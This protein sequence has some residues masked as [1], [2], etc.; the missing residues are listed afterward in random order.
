[1]TPGVKLRSSRDVILQL[2][3][4]SLLQ[5]IWF[6]W[7]GSH[8]G[9]FRACWWVDLLNQVGCSRERWKTPVINAVYNRDGLLLTLTWTMFVDGEKTTSIPPTCLL[10]RKQSLGSLRWALLSPSVVDG[11]RPGFRKALDVVWLARLACLFNIVWTSGTVPLNWQAGVRICFTKTETVKIC[12][13]V[14]ILCS[15][16]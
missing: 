11:I 8:A 14:F 13:S 4:L 10:M 3:H 5:L 2:F 1:M 12:R 7:S 16:F 6:K 9:S 15:A